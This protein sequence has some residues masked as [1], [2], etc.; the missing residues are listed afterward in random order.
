MPHPHRTPPHLR[1]LHSRQGL[2]RRADTAARR[3]RGPIHSAGVTMM[4]ETAP[5]PVP[6]PTPGLIAQLQTR[7]ALDH[8]AQGLAYAS[9]LITYPAPQFEGVD[10]AAVGRLMHGVAPTLVAVPAVLP[11]AGPCGT[12]RAARRTREEPPGHVPQAPSGT[13]IGPGRPA[14]PSR[15]RAAVPQTSAA[16]PVPSGRSSPPRMRHPG[17]T[18]VAHCHETN[19]WTGQVSGMVPGPTDARAGEAR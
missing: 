9:L 10:Q 13:G 11:E 16:P 8:T 18:E 19:T 7:T 17:R 4:S 5:A 2:P 15:G 1:T 6:A 3:G 14:Q 12:G